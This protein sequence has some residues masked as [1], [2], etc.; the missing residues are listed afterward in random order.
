MFGQI[1]SARIV[2]IVAIVVLLKPTRRPHAQDGRWA[3]VYSK[4]QCFPSHNTSANMRK[5]AYSFPTIF[6][7]QSKFTITTIKERKNISQHIMF[8]AC[9]LL[10]FLL[11]L[12]LRVHIIILFFFWV[13]SFVLLVQVWP[14]FIGLLLRFWAF[15]FACCPP[16]APPASPSLICNIKIHWRCSC[17]YAWGDSVIDGAKKWCPAGCSAA[18]HCELLRI[19]LA[20]WQQ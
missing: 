7:P 8:N 20:W 17:V 14:F 4:H 12:R 19:Y 11:P 1:C 5:H 3:G 16:A 18:N 2:K 13:S 9:K 6:Q 15:F 10:L